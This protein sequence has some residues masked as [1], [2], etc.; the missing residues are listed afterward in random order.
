M[1][2]SI[3]ASAHSAAMFDA[4]ELGATRLGIVEVAPGEH[5]HAVQPGFGGDVAELGHL[6]RV[7]SACHE[8]CM[9]W[10]RPFPPNGFSAGPT[11]LSEF[12]RP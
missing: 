3:P 2:T 6:D 4:C 7:V 12:G 5:A 9:L 8:G 1:V 10:G 11:A